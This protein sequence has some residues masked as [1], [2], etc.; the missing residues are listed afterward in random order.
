MGGWL[1]HTS[2]WVGGT[3]G[4]YYLTVFHFLLVLLYF[5]LSCPVSFF[6]VSGPFN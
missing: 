2:V 1:I 3:G 4:G 6:F 5:V